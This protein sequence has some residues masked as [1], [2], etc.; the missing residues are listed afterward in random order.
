MLLRN[1]RSVPWGPIL[2]LAAL[3]GFAA[4]PAVLPLDPFAQHIPD[5]LLPP[6]ARGSEGQSYLLGSD[7]LGRDMLARLAHGARFSLLVGAGA[8]VG[9]GAIGIVVGLLSGF[10]GGWIDRLLMRLVDLQLAFPFMV[11]AIGVLA[12]IGPSVLVVILL[13]ILARWPAFARIVRGATLEVKE[14]EFV[15]AARAM[16]ARN[17]RIIFRH[18]APSCIGPLLVLASFEMASVIIS[19]ASLG[20][21]GVGIPPPTPTWGNMLSGG[22]A[23]LRTA[24]WIVVMPGGAICIVA[25]AAN[26]VGDS[27]RDYLDPKT[28]RRAA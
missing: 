13:F 10:V 1:M 9:S 6:G 28:R 14:R 2:V 18:I 17:L 20:F 4:A 24:W 8:V 25:L 5:R 7:A 11:L 15:S 12:A 16:G 26:L 19:E 22:R 27:F 23:Y 21:L 3:M